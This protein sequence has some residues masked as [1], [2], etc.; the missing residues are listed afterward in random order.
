ML[1]KWTSERLIYSNKNLFLTQYL[2][3]NRLLKLNFCAYYKYNY[4]IY[5]LFRK[6]IYLNYWRFYIKPVNSFNIVT[7]FYKFSKQI[8]LKEVLYYKTLNDSKIVKNILPLNTKLFCLSPYLKQ[9]TKHFLK[10]LPGGLNAFIIKEASNQNVLMSDLDNS[11]NQTVLQKKIIFF[12]NYYDFF[13]LLNIFNLL[14]LVYLSNTV[15][16]YHI[17]IMSVFNKL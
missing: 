11:F 12:K 9:K 13:F 2:T 3:L 6:F 7:P 15:I 14:F 10:R 17:N 16:F 4:D 5:N 8:H 1:D